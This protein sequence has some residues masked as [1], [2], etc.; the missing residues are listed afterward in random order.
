[1]STIRCAWGNSAPEYVDYHDE[2]WGVPLHGDDALFERLCLEAFQSGLS[3]L[4]AV[5]C[6]AVRM[7][8]SPF[9]PRSCTGWRTA[10]TRSGVWPRDCEPRRRSGSGGGTRHF[11]APRTRALHTPPGPAPGLQGCMKHD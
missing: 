6:A 4:T 8:T 2:E 7:E 5:T 11:R 3:W 1:M 10:S 9:K